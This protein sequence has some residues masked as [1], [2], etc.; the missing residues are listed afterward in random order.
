M[1]LLTVPSVVYFD[2]NETMLDMSQVKS[3]IADALGNNEDLVPVW[4]STLLHHSLVDCASGG[5]HNF[6]E[7]GAAA[8][9][10]VAHSQGIQLSMEEATNKITGPM[11]SI[12]PHADV[13]ESLIKL[14]EK[15]FVLV[16]LSN[17]SQHGLEQQLA[18]AGIA[19][20]FNSVM[21]V[22]HLRI[23]KPYPQV[24]EAA[25]KKMKIS[26]QQGL[27]VAAHGWDVTGAKAVGMQ[28]AFVERPGKM[29]YPL[30]R[31]PDISVKDLNELTATL[32]AM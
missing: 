18:N 32:L 17:S 13:K 9:V 10:M 20:Y 14:A 11:T 30:G 19:P 28:T 16:A 1:P 15:G 29:M 21:S 8:L 26:A 22:E 23:Y 5:F 4:F 7:I 3:A 24:Y 12:P 31:E 25:L 2:V 27:M 6:T